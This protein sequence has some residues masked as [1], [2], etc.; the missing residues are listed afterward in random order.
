M[1][2]LNTIILITCLTAASGCS[3][4]DPRCGNGVIDSGEE[5]DGSVVPDAKQCPPGY[6][7]TGITYQCTDTCTI[8]SKDYEFC[9]PVCGNGKLDEGEECDGTLFTLEIPKC[10][11]EQVSTGLKYECTQNC[12][13]KDKNIVFCQGA[14]GNGIL[15]DGEDCDPG[16]INSDEKNVSVAQDVCARLLGPAY[17]QRDL[18][19]NE[20]S[21]DI[22]TCTVINLQDSPNMKGLCVPW[23]GNGQI[24]YDR[25][26]KCDGTVFDKDIP[27]CGEGMEKSG[28]TYECTPT[29]KLVDESPEFCQPICGNGIVNDGEECDP[30]H[31]NAYRKDFC[32][33]GMFLEG[34]V[35]CSDNCK[36]TNRTE[37]CKALCNDNI[38]VNTEY[39]DEENGIPYRMK[40]G[41]KEKIECSEFLDKPIWWDVEI[42][43]EN[44]EYLTGKPECYRCSEDRIGTC[45]Y[46]DKHSSSG[47]VSCESLINEQAT[48]NENGQKVLS[49]KIKM[50]K[51]VDDDINI[52]YTCVKLIPDITYEIFSQLLDPNSNKKYDLVAGLLDSMNRQSLRLNEI[53]GCPVS[54]PENYNVNDAS[55]DAP[56]HACINSPEDSEPF[57][58]FSVDLSITIP[59]S[60]NNYIFWCM[61]MYTGQ[62]GYQYICPPEPKKSESDTPEKHEKP[63][64]FPVVFQEVANSFGYASGFSDIACQ[65]CENISYVNFLNSDIIS[66]NNITQYH[67]AYDGAVTVP[68]LGSVPV[69]VD[70][71]INLCQCILHPDASM[72]VDIE[73]YGTRTLTFS[74]T[75]LTECLNNSDAKLDITVDLGFSEQKVQFPCSMLSNYTP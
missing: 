7:P 45:R 67:L 65:I 60:L 47:V 4:P 37:I 27:E 53:D 24:D 28:K 69:S 35:D 75:Q 74:C 66:C 9:R 42:M 29:C 50:I 2:Y 19:E 39:C 33:N 57:K 13:I 14:C 10:A 70:K 25:G 61:A 62:D 46:S 11:E 20:I 32:G 23:C 3:L 73:F 17:Q 31:V 56:L 44:E 38:L 64:S 21:C 55:K 15:E 68:F 34:D 8:L 30:G 72:S 22:Q 48:V 52:Y 40:D 26:E 6:E 41:Q 54:S 51:N 63:K 5:C 49:T 12:R 1:K 71:H 18:S 58:E 36:I 43:P 59:D 16:K